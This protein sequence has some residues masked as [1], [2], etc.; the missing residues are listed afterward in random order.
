[1]DIDYY[2]EQWS[3]DTEIDG[4][5]LDGESL[6][7]AKLHHKYYEFFVKEKLSLRKKESEFKQL[8]LDKHEF[9]S[10]GPNEETRAKG[11]VFPAK[12]MVLKSDL[13]MYINADKDIVELSLVIGY[14]TEIVNFLDGVIKFITFN[15]NK[16][17]SNAI[18][19]HKFTM[20]S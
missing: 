5:H 20:G 8:N 14:K 13:S 12:G 15:R 2:L 9:Y 1:M 18:E 7:T 16:S 3:K 4:T 19:W 11:W 10:Q 17:I 6:N